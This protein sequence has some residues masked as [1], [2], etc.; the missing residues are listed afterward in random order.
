MQNLP[1]QN[2]FNGYNFNRS[3][4]RMKS[5]NAKDIST[6][7]PFLRELLSVSRVE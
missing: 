3:R 1:N 6:R 5:K 4:T 2:L 7:R